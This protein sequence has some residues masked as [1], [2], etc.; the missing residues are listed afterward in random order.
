MGR[1]L[2]KLTRKRLWQLISS[3]AITIALFIDSYMHGLDFWKI[4][5]YPIAIGGVEGI[6]RLAELKHGRRCD[7]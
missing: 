7:R 3:I 1:I 4:L 6:Y 2:K 5:A